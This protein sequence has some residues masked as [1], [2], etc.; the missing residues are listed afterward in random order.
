MNRFMSVPLKCF[1]SASSSLNDALFSI[2]SCDICLQSSS[3]RMSAWAPLTWPGRLH[4]YVPLPPPS[5][6]YIS[7]MVHPVGRRSNDSACLHLRLCVH[8]R[9]GERR[10]KSLLQLD[11]N[12]PPCEA[13]LCP[14]ESKSCPRPP[15]PASRRCFDRSGLG[16]C[17]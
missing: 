11:P 5:P 3:A 6:S 10:M 2:Q 12:L 13:A 8:S 14:P 17:L 16:V 9:D 4:W 1:H 15:V 7:E